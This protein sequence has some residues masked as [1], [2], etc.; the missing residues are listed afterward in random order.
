M[1][2][3]SITFPKKQEIKEDIKRVDLTMVTIF[4]DL[5]ISSSEL[6]SHLLYY[7]L[8]NHGRMVET[9]IRISAR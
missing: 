6:N 4:S 2:G 5:F 1:I 8:P 3:N 9:I 7:Y